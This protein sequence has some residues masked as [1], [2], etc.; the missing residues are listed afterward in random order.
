M[1]VIL[2]R[3][4]RLYHYAQ[5]VEYFEVVGESYMHGKMDGEAVQDK[6]WVDEHKR[7]FFLR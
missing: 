1:P 6:H 7:S 2:R 3:G 5:S 4:G